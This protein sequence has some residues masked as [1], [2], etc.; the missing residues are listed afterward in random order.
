M[1]F[2]SITETHDSAPT[3]Y[4]KA[5]LIAARS[6]AYFHLRHDAQNEK[7]F[8]VYSST[9][10]QLY[11]GYHAELSMP[12]VAQ[13]QRE[14]YGQMVTYHNEPV[15]TPYSSRTN[16]MTRGW[17]QAWGGT[18]K[19]WLVPV[20]ALYDKGKK[21]NGHGVGMSNNDAI[22]RAKNDG[23]SYSRILEYYYSGTHVEKIY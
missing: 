15:I 13:M 7:L 22:L 11:L 4:I 1:L 16:G 12:R 2:R 5:L 14:T 10:D 6:Y 21:R 18:D 3:E 9:V 8:D 20:E 23:W 17:K 19:P